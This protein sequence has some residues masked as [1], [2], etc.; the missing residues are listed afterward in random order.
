MN[1]E[2]TTITIEDTFWILRKALNQ[3]NILNKRYLELTYKSLIG[4]P[5]NDTINEIAINH[6]QRER[7]EH[8]LYKFLDTYVFTQE[9]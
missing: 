8:E 2:K 5:D 6:A 4:L 1:E 9:H 3:L 7:I